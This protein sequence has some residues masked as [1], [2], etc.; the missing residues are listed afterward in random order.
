MKARPV[1][2]WKSF[3]LGVL[4][5]CFLG[6]AWWEGYAWLTNVHWSDSD[7]WVG[8]CHEKGVTMMYSMDVSALGNT[9]SGWEWQRQSTASYPEGRSFRGYME[10]LAEAGLPVVYWRVRDAVVFSSCL[11]LWVGWLVWRWRRARVMR[12]DANVEHR[13]LNAE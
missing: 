5:L 2:R 7:R 3:W 1:W 8:A 11:A 6:W 10:G 9:S 4:V 13:T 12:E